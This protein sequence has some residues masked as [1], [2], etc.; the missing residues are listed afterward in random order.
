VL[1]VVFGLAIFGLWLGAML[2]V[3]K[4]RRQY[5]SA[6]AELIRTTISFGMIVG[7]IAVSIIAAH[8]TIS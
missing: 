6:H 4:E 7:V 1:N 8:H 5:R 3:R 2:V